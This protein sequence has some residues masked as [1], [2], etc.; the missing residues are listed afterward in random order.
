MFLGVRRKPSQSLSVD[1]PP[2]K[3]KRGRK[4]KSELKVE[5]EFICSI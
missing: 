5:E 3:K 2:V 4:P 1:E